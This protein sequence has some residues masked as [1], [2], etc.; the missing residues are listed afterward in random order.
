[1]AVFI[2][3]THRDGLVK[4][5]GICSTKGGGSSTGETGLLNFTPFCV[6]GFFRSGRRGINRAGRGSLK[7]RTRTSTTRIAVWSE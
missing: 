1:M 5:W 2:V 7:G 4:V 6:V 3:T